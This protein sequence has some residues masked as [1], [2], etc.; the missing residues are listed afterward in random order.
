MRDKTYN[1]WTNYATW[2]V[3]LWVDNE[4][5]LYTIRCDLLKIAVGPIDGEWVRS[6]INCYMNG[7]TPDLA[8]NDWEG[9][10]IQDVNWEEIAEHWEEE[11]LELLDYA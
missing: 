2:N 6:F 9:G 11:R 8:G 3:P 7:T 1:G 10:R 5:S 4:Y